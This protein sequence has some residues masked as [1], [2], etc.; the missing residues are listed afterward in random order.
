MFNEYVLPFELA[1][2]L[3]LTAIISAVLIGKKIYKM[4]EVTNSMLQAVPIEHYIILCSLLFS[5]GV[6]GVLIR[7]MRLLFLDVLS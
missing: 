6:L 2:V 5:L 3:I 4:G 1:S 7:K